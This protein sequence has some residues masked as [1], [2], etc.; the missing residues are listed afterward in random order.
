LTDG[1]NTQNRFSTTQSAIDNRTQ[2]ACANIKDAG[3]T[4][5]TLQ[6]NTDG[7]PT[8]T[9][10]QQCA[11]DTGKFFLVTSASQITTIFNQIGT[12]LSQLR[13]AK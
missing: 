9:M 1:L 6:V 7:D 2:K 12:N 4:L 10:L 11:T 5:Y 8:S 13:I 3:I